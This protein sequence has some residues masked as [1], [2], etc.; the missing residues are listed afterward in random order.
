MKY[1]IT[2]SCETGLRTVFLFRNYYWVVELFQFIKELN[3][4][5][6]GYFL[7]MLGW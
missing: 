7:Y 1:V 2:C 5:V 3:A 6:N 4:C